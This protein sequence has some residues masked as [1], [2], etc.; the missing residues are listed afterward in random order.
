MSLISRIITFKCVKVT[1]ID[2]YGVM[3]LT[4]TIHFVD[5]LGL[6]FNFCA[7]IIYD[8]LTMEGVIELDFTRRILLDVGT[9]TIQ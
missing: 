7:L 4:N 5:D 2:H 8:N 1:K 3:V 6:M 9:R